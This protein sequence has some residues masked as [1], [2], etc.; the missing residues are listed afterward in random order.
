MTLGEPD[1]SGRRR[2][3]PIEGSEFLIEADMV[4]PAIGQVVDLSLFKGRSQLEATRRG[5]G[6]VFLGWKEP[7]DGARSRLT[8]SNAAN[9]PPAIG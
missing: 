3:I 8:R 9:A 5:E 7:I 1:D 2:P 6:W 4:I